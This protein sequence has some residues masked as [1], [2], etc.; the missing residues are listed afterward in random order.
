MFF[1]FK[2]RC[3]LF[4]IYNPPL[5][6]I[7]IRRRIIASVDTTVVGTKGLSKNDRE[8]PIYIDYPSRLKISYICV[9]ALYGAVSDGPRIYDCFL[10]LNNALHTIAAVNTDVYTR[11][12][13]VYERET[14]SFFSLTIITTSLR[15]FFH[16]RPR[17][18]RINFRGAVVR[19]FLRHN[20]DFKIKS[21]QSNLSI[22][23]QKKNP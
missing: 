6:L 8:T 14:F 19:A 12:V 21:I 9:T 5:L 13:V 4:L 11:S 23:Q 1:R 10:I 3:C 18:E 20:V 15:S 17:N 2:I 22:D 7:F 16:V